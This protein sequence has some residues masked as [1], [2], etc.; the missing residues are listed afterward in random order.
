M[1]GHGDAGAGA[2]A[3]REL[4]GHSIGEELPER[5]GNGD[6]D[7]G[8]GERRGGAQE[9]SSATGASEV[10]RSKQRSYAGRT[11]SG[12]RWSTSRRKVPRFSAVPSALSALARSASKLPSAST[13]RRSGTRST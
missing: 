11:A 13:V 12:C 8:R 10:T 7:E 1:E 5:D 9:A 6:L 4:L 2:E 3:S